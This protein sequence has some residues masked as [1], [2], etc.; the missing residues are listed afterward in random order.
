MV[1]SPGGCP[2]C[3]PEIPLAFVKDKITER[4]F[5]YCHSCDS[6]WSKPTDPVS[7]IWPESSRAFAPAG[8]LLATYEELTANG[9]ESSV[10]Q[11]YG[12]D[13]DHIF[14]SSRLIRKGK[15]EKEEEEEKERKGRE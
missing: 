14:S 11:E 10:N 13:W 15:E 5:V 12:D 6:S 2:V 3:G 4:I 8:A 1:Y 7:D 9:L